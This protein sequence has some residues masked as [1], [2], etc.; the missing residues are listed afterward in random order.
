MTSTS[1]PVTP[2]ALYEDAAQRLR[3]RLGR[4]AATAMPPT[5]TTALDLFL[6]APH[7]ATAAYYFDAVLTYGDIARL[8]DRLAGRLAQDGVGRGDRVAVI[9][10]NVPQFLIVTVA[11]WKLGAIVVSLNPMYRTPELEKLFRDCEPKAV[12]CHD[13]QWTTVHPAAERASASIFWTSARE[14]QTRDDARVLPST[15]AAPAERALATIFADGSLVAPPRPELGPDDIGLLLYTSGTTGV[16]K[17]AM[18]T[19]RNLVA[20]VEICCAHFEISAQSRIFGIAPLFHITGF[21]L[22]LVAAFA[23]AAS[24]VL[25]YRFQPQVALDAFLEWRPTFVV[26]AITAFIALMNQPNAEGRHFDSFAHIYSGGAPIAPSVVEAFAKRFGRAIHSSYGMTELTSASHLAPNEGRIPIDPE[27]GALSI[28]KPTLEADVIV[29]DDARRPLGPGEHGEVVV[30]G[31]G[32]MIGYW[33]KPAETAEVLTEGWLHSGDVGFFDDDGWF[34]LVDRK[35]D[36]ISASG[37]KVWPREVE[38]AI[39]AFPGV[40]EAAVV[41]AADS[42]RGETVVAFV[43]A[44]PGAVIDVAALSRFC[45]ERL[46]AYKCPAEFRVLADLPKT[47]SGKITRNTLRDGLR[48]R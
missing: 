19:H 6:A 9:L 48:S 42:Y 41:G 17:G 8:S 28:G 4:S 29:V 31:P 5:Q 14:F 45:R 16:P 36:M 33:R 46:A 44:Q 30:R 27:S 22:Q 35:K 37:F 15:V 43:S 12:I 23:K 25:T 47:E 40:R 26:G 11:I 34:Y 7:E 39:Y 21:E 38:D 24:V 1:D 10:Q 3:D 13:D 18:L 2:V 20:N 32:V